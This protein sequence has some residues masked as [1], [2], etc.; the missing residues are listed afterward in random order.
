[1]WTLIFLWLIF[2]ISHSFLAATNVRSFFEQLTPNKPNYYRLMYNLIALFLLFLI[3]VKTMEVNSE[4]MENN[5]FLI[6]LMGSA[7]VLS[8]F[9]V[10]FGVAKQM[11]LMSF[12]GF[13]SEEMNGEL[14][15]GGWYTIVRHPLY[16]GLLVL[17]LG[18]LLLF[19]TVGILI[20]VAFSKLYIIVGIEFE[21]KKL[22]RIFG[23]KYIDFSVGKKKFIPFIY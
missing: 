19:P 13:K 3:A 17:F 1:M 7:L 2:G 23:Q 18:I 22:R 12:F 11:D 8:S 10:L 21:E 5:Y 15:T 14:M 9:Y 4:L 6:K 16:F 20:S